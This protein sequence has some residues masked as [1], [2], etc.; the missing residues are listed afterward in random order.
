MQSFRKPAAYGNQFQKKYI[1]PNDD[2]LRYMYGSDKTFN[3]L[4]GPVRSGKTT[5]NITMFCETVDK[6]PDH[7]FL[8]IGESQPTAKTILWEGDGLG[9]AH[10][11]DWQA[12]VYIHEGKR[13]VRQQRIFKT[14]YQGKEAL[15]LLPKSG[16][17]H[18]VK[19]IIAFGGTKSN[20]HEGYKGMSIGAWIATQWELLH[21]ETRSELLKRTI[22][23]RLR[24][25]YIDLNPIS[26]KAEIYREFDRWIKKGLVNYKKKLM[27]ENTSL[28]AERIEEI[29]GEYDPD[30]IAYKRDIL[31]ERAVAEG[32]IYN[33]R[34]YNLLDDMTYEEFVSNVRNNYRKFV[35]VADI[36]EQDSATVFLLIGLTRDNQY[37]DVLTEYYHKNADEPK[38][39]QK[40]SYDYVKDYQNFILD[41]AELVQRIPREI[42]SDINLDFVREYERT[43]FNVGL[44][45]TYLNYQFKKDE[46]NDRIKEGQKLLAQGR[47][48]FS[49]Y[50]PKTKEAFETAVYDPKAEDK[51][52][53]V[54]LDDP[55]QGTMID[56]I[57]G[58]EYAMSRVRQDMQRYRG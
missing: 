50:V 14:Q 22:A 40:L 28:T 35:I 38:N 52:V 24:K 20:D 34:D 15:A 32:L 56:P 55:K 5:D 57:D 13:V 33:V 39:N 27:P 16:S 11:P 51:G 7:L 21:P 9:I 23:S 41:S 45:A 30:S 25:H 12:G 26:H 37:L 1:M 19:Y 54:R 17:G 48:R 4:E 18:S 44:G 6:S 58:T 42:L 29:K 36:G 53:F 10:Y 2:T 46:I 8:T 43:K 3:I 49:R 31:G 47:L